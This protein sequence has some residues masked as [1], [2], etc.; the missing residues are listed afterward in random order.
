MNSIDIGILVIM[1]ISCLMG[2]WRGFTREI[3]GL[4]T[5]LGSVVAT[6]IA[7]PIFGGIARSYISNPMLADT[8]TA[9]VLFIIFLIIFSIISGA[10]SNSVKSSS[11]GGID[12]A[13]G[14][15]FGI[16]RGVIVICGLEIIISTFTIRQN[17][18][19][20]IQN[21]RFT[22]MVRHGADSL[23]HCLPQSIQQ[24]IISQQT[25][26]IAKSAHQPAPSQQETLNN[27]VA[28][29]LKDTVT[30]KLKTPEEIKK[31]ILSPQQP[32]HGQQHRA[33]QNTPPATVTSPRIQEEDREKTAESLAKLTPQATVKE[34]ADGNYDK[35]QRRDLDRLVQINQ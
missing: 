30:K 18:S 7:I 33:A 11:L 19:E 28:G 8:A 3:L 24:F 31:L 13:L 26:S 14:F 4:F 16:V 15:S 20:T 17:Q 22:T 27:I 23:T 10:L 25:E 35:R 6:Y 5:W 32:S 2:F 34:G 21:A 9:V 1:S 29:A 12:H